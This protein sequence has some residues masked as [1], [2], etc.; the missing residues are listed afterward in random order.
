MSSVGSHLSVSL[1]PPPPAPHFR[2]LIP[3]SYAPTFPV[4]LLSLFFSFFFFVLFPSSPLIL[5]LIPFLFQHTVSMW[6]ARWVCNVSIKQKCLFFSVRKSANFLIPFI[7]LLE[8]SLIKTILGLKYSAISQRSLGIYKTF[9]LTK[10]A[11]TSYT[12]LL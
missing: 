6:L 12:Q 2:I 7:P 10:W 5:F 4:S 3:E 11:Q 8:L 9:I 1:P